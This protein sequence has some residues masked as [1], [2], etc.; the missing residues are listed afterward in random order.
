MHRFLVR[1]WILVMLATTVA[2]AAAGSPAGISYFWPPALDVAIFKDG[3]AYVIR[4]GEAEASADGVLTE[5]IPRPILGTL[6]VY[7]L[8]EG[9]RVSEVVA[10]YDE[11]ETTAKIT[12]V[13]AFYHQ[14]VGQRLALECGPQRVEGILRGVLSPGHLLVETGAGSVLVPL[15][16]VTRL[17]L[18]GAAALDVPALDRRPRFRIRLTGPARRVRL[19]LS[20]LEES[21]AWYPSYRV[22]LRPDNQAELVLTATVVNNAEDV[23]GA[24]LHLIV[25]VPNFMMRGTLSPMVLDVD[26]GTVVKTGRPPLPSQAFD[27]LTRAYAVP[28]S[29]AGDTSD[30]TPAGSVEDLFIYEKKGFSLGLGQR[31]Q[32][33]LF[34]GLVPCE[35]IYQWTLPLPGDEAYGQRY[36]QQQGKFQGEQAGTI[37]HYLRLTNNTIVPWTTAPAM[38]VSGWQPVAQDLMKYVAIGGRHDLRVTVAP[39][40][41]G[42]AREE[43]TSRK[44]VRLFGNDDYLQI[45]VRGTLNIENLKKSAVRVEVAKDLWGEVKEAGGG[46]LARKPEYL[47]KINPHSR[48][49]WQVEV[50]AGGKRVLT[51]SYEL[52]VDI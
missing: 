28:E 9:A 21:W 12:D 6:D 19:G 29:P 3:C 43:E 33:E 39:E 10:F 27:N 40:V 31:M 48:L 32:L 42:E 14:Q 46:K 49:D 24:V 16:D 20:Y 23:N 4:E 35:S 7:S 38:V 17:T 44:T 36:L 47:W 41:R 18:P 11:A 34:R 13:E 45:T 5:R 25:G 8:T 1:F 26:T 51:Y 2:V 52:Y 30:V 37:W 22:N 15:A 50:P